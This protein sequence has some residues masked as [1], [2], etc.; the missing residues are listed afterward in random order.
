VQT[1]ELPRLCGVLVVE[2]SMVV[3]LG[4]A[5]THGHGYIPRHPSSSQ[6]KM[7]FSVLHLGAASRTNRLFMMENRLGIEKLHK[8]PTH[9]RVRRFVAVDV[10]GA[11]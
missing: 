8:L 9:R 3:G 11:L 1:T 10:H 5:R 6:P 7:K 2:E 4:T